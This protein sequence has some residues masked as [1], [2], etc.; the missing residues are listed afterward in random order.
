MTE[1]FEAVITATSVITTDLLDD[2]QTKES[3]LNRSAKQA[4]DYELMIEFL[5]N[6]IKKTFE[7]G[8]DIGT[9][10]KEF[11]PLDTN[12]WKPSIEVS[13]APEDEI[14][15]A[16]IQQFGIEFKADYEA[17]HKRLQTYENNLTKAYALLWERCMKG[18]KK[19]RLKHNQTKNQN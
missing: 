10:L 1:E 3:S 5:I 17:Y 19:I 13:I 14:R 7:F 12:Q 16:E 11:K 18:I 15:G 2:H 9:A 4:S 6:H 8:K